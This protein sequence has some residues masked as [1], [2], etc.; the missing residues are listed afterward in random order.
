MDATSAAEPITALLPGRVGIIVRLAAKPGG[1]S[2]LLDAIN[3]YVDGL[4]DQHGE[5]HT[6]AFVIATDPADESVVWLFEWFGSQSGLDKHRETPSFTA[7]VGRLP[8]LLA[9]PPGILRIDPL[10][11]HLRSASLDDITEWIKPTP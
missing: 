5:P 7:L 8:E 4:D 10:R 6:E 1:R 9:D 2:A 11:L 3:Q